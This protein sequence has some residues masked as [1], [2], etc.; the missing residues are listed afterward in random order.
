MTS[1]RRLDEWISGNVADLS[2][3]VAIGHQGEMLLLLLKSAGQEVLD[4]LPSVSRFE[5]DDI[6]FRLHVRSIVDR[7]YIRLTSIA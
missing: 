1:L 4:E 7:P 5:L 3:I 2:N 6:N